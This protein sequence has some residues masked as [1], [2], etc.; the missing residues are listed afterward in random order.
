M[1]K[2]KIASASGA[3]SPN[4][5]FPSAIGGSALR[6]LAFYFRLLLQHC[7]GRF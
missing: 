6:L 4:L 3:L 7:R 5:R 2:L 1:K